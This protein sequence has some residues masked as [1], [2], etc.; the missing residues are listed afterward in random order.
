MIT[1]YKIWDDTALLLKNKNWWWWCWRWLLTVC[2]SDSS[3]EQQ[4][5]DTTETCHVQESGSALLQKIQSPKGKFCFS[6]FK[7][8]RKEMTYF[9]FWR[10]FFTCWTTLY[11][12]FQVI[13]VGV[14][15]AP[16][17]CLHLRCIWWQEAPFMLNHSE[18][19]VLFYL[20]VESVFFIALCFYFYSLV[21]QKWTKPLSA[22]SHADGNF[23][24]HSVASQL[25][26]SPKQLKQMGA[27][28]KM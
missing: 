2:Q 26:H 4:D 11:L 23:V 25:Q 17:V 7:A 20:Q 5:L 1:H 15:I 10:S 6:L 28:F 14:N 12:W 19:D 8:L 16:T 13:W 3:P 9:T 18:H 21:T 27:C 22:H 24:V